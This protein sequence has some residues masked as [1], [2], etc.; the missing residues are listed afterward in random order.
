[1]ITFFLCLGAFLG[2]VLAGAAFYSNDQTPLQL[3]PIPFFGGLFL[4]IVCLLSAIARH[5]V[6]Q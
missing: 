4:F 6:W 5:L 1:M 2:A 3:G